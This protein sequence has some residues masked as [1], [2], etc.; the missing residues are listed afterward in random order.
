MVE[1]IKVPR[2]RPWFGRFHLC[3]HLQVQWAYA[4]RGLNHQSLDRVIESSRRW[5]HVRV[6]HGG[7]WRAEL[8]ADHQNQEDLHDL[9]DF[10]LTATDHKL[11]IQRNRMWI[12][13]NDKTWLE[14]LARFPVGRFQHIAQVVLQGDANAVNL[15]SSDHQWRS[16]FRS[17]RVDPHT[18]ESLRRFLDNQADIRIGPGL[19]SA[20]DL[21]HVRLKD[22]YFIDHSDPSVLN[23]MSLIDP[24]LIRKTVPIRVHK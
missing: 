11:V 4:L 17:K 18:L 7:S 19:R 21:G 2:A 6:N 10:L 5:N 24:G 20:L 23:M 8:G 22:Y 9:C 1:S 15:C 3:G 12:Y 16:F 14:R 13:T